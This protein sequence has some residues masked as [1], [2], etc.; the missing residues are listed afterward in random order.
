[1]AADVEVGGDDDRTIWGNLTLVMVLR[2]NNGRLGLI[3]VRE[4][5]VRWHC[6]GQ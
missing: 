2:A 3:V 6:A 4:I 1:V 5:E